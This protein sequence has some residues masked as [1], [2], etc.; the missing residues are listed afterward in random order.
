MGQGPFITKL[1][2]KLWEQ[3]YFKGFN[4]VVEIGSQE[5]HLKPA[6]FEQLL[7]SAQITNYKKEIFANLSH[8][9]AQPRCS[10]K[11]FYELLGFKKYVALDCNG[12][13]GAI[14]H[15]LNYPLED[16]A[17]YNQFDLVTDYGCNEHAFNVGEAYRTLHRL[18]KPGG[19]MIIFQALLGGNGYYLFDLSFL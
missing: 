19:L 4:S 18:C 9:P 13:H 16:K 14:K 17:L 5:L 2:L 3:G 6:A 10:T 8:Y 15:D 11:P 1:N 12:E 7:K